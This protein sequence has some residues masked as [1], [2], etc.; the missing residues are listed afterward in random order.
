[1]KNL[2]YILIFIPSLLFSQETKNM[3]LVG[4]RNVTIEKLDNSSNSSLS[5]QVD[6]GLVLKIISLTHSAVFNGDSK[7]LKVNNEYI[8]Y[9]K[10][11]NNLDVY[12]V[13]FPFFLPSGIH[14]LT[15][16]GDYEGEFTG[17]IYGL[18]FK[19]TTP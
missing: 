16:G 3:E 4:V 7:S 13:N 14:Q 5:F 11:G 15:I 9:S 1:M 6:S 17:T 19:L 2:L 18:E 10:D 8:F 12:T